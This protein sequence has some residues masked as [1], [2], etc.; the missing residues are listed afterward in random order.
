MHCLQ[1]SCLVF[2]GHQTNHDIV[3]GLLCWCRVDLFVFESKWGLEPSYIRR[4]IQSRSWL[5]FL[6]DHG[7]WVATWRPSRDKMLTLFEAAQSTCLFMFVQVFMCFNLHQDKHCTICVSFLQVAYHYVWG[8][9][10]FLTK[11]VVA[12]RK[13]ETPKVPLAVT[14]WVLDSFGKDVA[15]A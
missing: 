2:I 15:N 13:P 7:V 1:Y 6:M 12:Y 3:L 9:A 5:S 8:L 14:I 11:R 10:M 4:N